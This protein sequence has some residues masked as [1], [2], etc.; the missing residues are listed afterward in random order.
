MPDAS[1]LTVANGL[2][3]L[4]ATGGDEFVT[5]FR[6]GSLEVELYRPDGVDRQTPH[7]RDELYVIAAGRGSFVLEGERQPVESGEVLFVAAGAAHR[8]VDFTDDFAT[9]V[10]FYGP[11][12]G[13]AEAR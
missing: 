4:D 11:D 7:R 10:V 9:W 12:G 3:A 5:L 8:F 13:E 1:R 2:A 6:H